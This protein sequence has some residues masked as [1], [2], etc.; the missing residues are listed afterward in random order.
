MDE[1]DS[2]RSGRPRLRILGILKDKAQICFLV[3]FSNS[4]KAFVVSLEA[5]RQNYPRQLIEF[6]EKRMVIL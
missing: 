4:P 3:Q 2:L 6:Y 5:I 1:E